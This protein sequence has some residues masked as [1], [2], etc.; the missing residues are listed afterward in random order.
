VAERLIERFRPS[1]SRWLGVAGIVMIACM[2]VLIAADGLTWTATA[3]LA[4]LALFG[5]ALYVSLVRPT[6][7]A[8]NDHLLVRNLVSDTQVPWHL[9]TD[10]EVRQTMRLYTRDEVVHAVSV[11]RTVG[12][13]MRRSGNASLSGSA[14][15][16]GMSRADEY[17]AARTARAGNKGG[18][19]YVDF[20]AERVLTLAAQQ[21]DESRHRP[22]IVRRWAYPEIVTLLVAGAAFL[23][24]LIVAAQ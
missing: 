5:V 11:G 21:R 3:V 10:A 4:G 24:L 14:G 13:Q 22:R 1:G 18:V 20:V 17:A 16:F 2:L 6:M 19:D 7:H 15:S 23:V 9:I 12:Q 8:Y